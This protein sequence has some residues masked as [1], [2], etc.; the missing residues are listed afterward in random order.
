MFT[1]NAKSSLYEHVSHLREQF[2]IAPAS[3]PLQLA[4]LFQQHAICV[5]H[6]AF[7]TPGLCALAFL[8]EKTDTV[9]LNDN[10]SPLEQ[11]FD[12]GHE[13]IHLT[14]HRNLKRDYFNCFTT[15]KPSQS[16]FLEW[17]A[18]EGAAEL[19]VPYQVFLPLLLEES[20]IHCRAPKKIIPSLARQFQVTPAVIECR[21]GSLQY[22]LY[23]YCILQLPLCDVK[24]HSQRELRRKHLSH[25]HAFSYYCPQCLFQVNRDDTHCRY[26]GASMPPEGAFYGLGY[27][28]H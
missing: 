4:P 3:F 5:E 1:N 17:E 15:A 13:L 12:C 11:N 25:L 20:R 27:R 14:K 6:R 21:I 18:N 19:L 28:F 8:G 10:R 24:L 16:P 26:C 7:Q 9:V 23:Q 22:E 2:H